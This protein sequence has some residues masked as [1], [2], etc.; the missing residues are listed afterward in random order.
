MIVD[1]TNPAKLI[2][3]AAALVVIIQQK[4]RK[5]MSWKKILLLGLILAFTASS[6]MAIEGETLVKGSTCTKKL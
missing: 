2:D 3:K 6:V 5:I 1:K 4:E